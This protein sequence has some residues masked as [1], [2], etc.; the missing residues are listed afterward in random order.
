VVRRS[1]FA[2]LRQSFKANETNK[3][4]LAGL[5]ADSSRANAQVQRLFVST[6]VAK[7]E[8]E[9]ERY[10]RTK[11]LNAFL[12][13]TVS[14][15]GTGL[16]L[17]S[18]VSVQ[19]AGDIL[20]VAGGALTAFFNICTAD[21][22]VPDK[23]D[24]EMKGPLPGELASRTK[25][26]IIPDTVWDVLDSA[27]KAVLV[28]LFTT[29]CGNKDLPLIHL[30]CHWGAPPP[31]KCAVKKSYALRRLNDDLTAVSSEANKLLVAVALQ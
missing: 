2:S 12:G 26:Q 5:A 15:I 13:T 14:T 20:G 31:D 22:N 4:K 9:Q 27:E 21:W 24:P 6:L 18:D 16:Q 30:S 23:P 7:Q 17:N 10:K 29:S 11:Y 8:N 1:C 25:P 19:H 28:H 3:E